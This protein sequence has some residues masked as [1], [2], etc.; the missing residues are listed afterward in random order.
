M[1]GGITVDCGG[2]A[3]QLRLTTRA[4]MA[5][6]E[7][8]DKTIIEIGSQMETGFGVTQM[9]SMLAECMDGGKGA[10]TEEAQDL[11]DALGFTVAVEK[12]GK[13]FEAAFPE[14][15]KKGNGPGAGKSK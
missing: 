11:I 8:F 10:A 12:F 14:A 7:R 5:I 3:Y 9:V 2:A 6:E 4:M 15:K 13:V 1:I